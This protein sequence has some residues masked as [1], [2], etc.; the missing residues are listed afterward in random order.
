MSD[1]FAFWA[2]EVER[3]YMLECATDEQRAEYDRRNSGREIVFRMKRIE[4]R[5]NVMWPDLTNG[6]GNEHDCLVQAFY[7]LRDIRELR[8]SSRAWTGE[9]AERADE[10]QELILREVNT[11]STV[12]RN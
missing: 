3:C 12:R 10:I 4:Q 6:T 1:F 11:P 9:A 5:F 7:V 8:K 2:S